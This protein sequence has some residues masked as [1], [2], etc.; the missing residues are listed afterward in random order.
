MD[1]N[2]TSQH[3]PSL[4][5]HITVLLQ[6]YSHQLSVKGVIITLLAVWLITLHGPYVHA[7]E[8]CI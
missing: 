4:S 3:H 5:F 1:Y 8:P 6:Y 7:Q 2:V